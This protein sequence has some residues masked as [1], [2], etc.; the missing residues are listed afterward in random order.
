[1]VEETEAAGAMD[2]ERFS[3]VIGRK[4]FYDHLS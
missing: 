2:Y 1:M 3:D 4:N